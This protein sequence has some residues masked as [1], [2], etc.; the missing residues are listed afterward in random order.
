MKPGPIFVQ[1]RK[2]IA[3]TVAA[4]HARGRRMFLLFGAGILGLVV[5]GCA[6]WIP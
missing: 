6:V 4:S 1:P 3:P 5:A 2:V